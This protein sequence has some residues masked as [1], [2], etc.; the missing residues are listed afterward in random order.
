MSLPT[1]R[2][3]ST[4]RASDGGATLA[5]PKR[6]SSLTPAIFRGTSTRTGLQTQPD[7]TRWS[8]TV[9]DDFGASGNFSIA[10]GDFQ[11]NENGTEMKKAGASFEISE[12]TAES[13]Q[14]HEGSFAP[15]FDPES[16]GFDSSLGPD[17]FANFG[18]SFEIRPET[19]TTEEWRRSTSQA[20]AAS[21]PPPQFDPQST[22]F[23]SSLGPDT[24]AKFGS[25]VP[26]D[27]TTAEAPS[28]PS[29]VFESSKEGAL[30]ADFDSSAADIPCA[31]KATS[32]KKEVTAAEFEASQQE[33]LVDLRS[34]AA[35]PAF[36]SYEHSGAQ[37]FSY[38]EGP[39]SFVQFD[40]NSSK[41]QVFN[42]GDDS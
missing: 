31:R 39:E 10:G 26:L 35:G 1:D 7:H 28:S 41:P 34:S 33:S 27:Y 4:K 9:E 42:V 13:T 12:T 30:F 36:A 5:P 17:T 22:E 11:G 3:T 6:M 25:A 19:A 37:L 38:S 20:R 24:F 14:A 32:E 16:T 23:D 40:P 18:L 21:A 8:S 2:V 29:L 15:H